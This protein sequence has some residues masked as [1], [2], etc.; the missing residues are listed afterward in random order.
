MKGLLLLTVLAS[1][2]VEASPSLILEDPKL[3][4]FAQ[5]NIMTGAEIELKCLGDIKL[6][7]SVENIGVDNNATVIFVSTE[8]GYHA[9]TVRREE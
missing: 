3:T 5:N 7:G 6:S 1:G 8:G 9:F 4:C 2:S